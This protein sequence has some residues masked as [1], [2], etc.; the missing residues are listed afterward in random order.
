MQQSVW[1]MYSLIQN[2][3]L[4]SCQSVF[5]LKSSLCLQILK[6][7]YRE[8]FINGFKKDLKS[9]RLEIFLKY[10]SG[11]P[12]IKKIQPISKPGRRVYVSVKTL[13]KLETSLVTYLLSTPIGVLTDKECRQYHQS[14]EVLCI[15]Y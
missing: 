8:G 14:G 3:S 2:G 12:I 9:N 13:W 7:L 15:I 6:T 1:N 4:A 5:S 11:T 10:N